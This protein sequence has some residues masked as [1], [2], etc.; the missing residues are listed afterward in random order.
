VL[1][2]EG[3]A[4]LVSEF[5]SD[6]KTYYSVM[7]A[8][9]SGKTRLS[10]IATAF[11]N[12]MILANRYI[13]MIRRE[14]ELVAKVS[15]IADAA[16]SKRG[17]YE[18]K[19]N[20]FRFWFRFIKRHE[21]LVEQGRTKELEEII[22]EEFNAFAGRSFEDLCA[23]LIKD[24]RLGLPFVPQA[25]GRQWGAFRGESGRNEYEI[26]IAAFNEKTSQ[27]L[28]AECKWKDNVD[29]AEVL[30][31]LKEKA[32]HVNWKAGKRKEYFAVFAKS[33]KKTAAEKDVLCI[34]L[35]DIEK[36]LA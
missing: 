8:I 2:E 28:F 13:D 32:A 19:N 18:I 3:K 11:E 23:R 30:R 22:R 14:Y 31:L 17:K 9:S 36:A 16:D 20:F 35:K 24:G 6:Y 25:A 34:D 12:D 10:E 33:F 5:G 27:I 21:S 4:I 26:D 29:A 15:P 1:S 7:E